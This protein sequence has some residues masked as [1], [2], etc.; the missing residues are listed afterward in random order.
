MRGHTGLELGGWMRVWAQRHGSYVGLHLKCRF[1]DDLDSWLK[2][3]KLK[4]VSYGCF[5]LDANYMLDL[6]YWRGRS[7]IY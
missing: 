7:G 5:V 3:K 1:N 4:R 6:T 2:R